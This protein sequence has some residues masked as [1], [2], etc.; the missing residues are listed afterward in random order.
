MP[1]EHVKRILDESVSLE[2]LVSDLYLLFST[3]YPE[4]REFWWRMA[5][6]EKNHASLLRSTENF[7]RVGVFPEE[8]LM[9]SLEA[10]QSAN[11]QISELIRRMREAPLPKAEA[12]RA[13]LQIELSAAELHY[14]QLMEEDSGDRVMEI[15]RKLGSDDKDH[16]ERIASLMSSSGIPEK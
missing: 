13:A 1:L 9:T 12:Y 15:I 10:L 2:L 14:Q 5:L 16:A 7:M 3:T 4:D 6:E 8:A 11:A